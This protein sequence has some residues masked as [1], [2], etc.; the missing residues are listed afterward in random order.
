MCKFCYDILGPTIPH[1]ES[2]CALKQA[3]VCPICGPC[4]HFLADCP[5][6]IKQIS[7]STTIE[8]SRFD[9]RTDDPYL[10][11][12]TNLGYIEYQKLHKLEV[13]SRSEKNKL[14]VEEHLKTRGFKLVVPPKP[15]ILPLKPTETL[16]TLSHGGNQHC[17]VLQQ[18]PTNKKILIRRK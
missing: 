2:D 16:C 18:Q 4:T 6:K 8:E 13:H 11:G 5:K 10:M 3:S 12:D 14:I 7:Y 17:I 1:K 15:S 9:T